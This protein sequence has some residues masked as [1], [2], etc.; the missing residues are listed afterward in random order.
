MP[1]TTPSDG[2]SYQL[3]ITTKSTKI[4]VNLSWVSFPAQGEYFASQCGYCSSPLSGRAEDFAKVTIDH[5]KTCAPSFLSRANVLGRS[6]LSR[7]QWIG[8]SVTIA[9]LFA[10]LMWGK[11]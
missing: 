11:P 1:T 4:D 8:W 10:L 6:T 9:G 7:N 2:S 5:S 3:N